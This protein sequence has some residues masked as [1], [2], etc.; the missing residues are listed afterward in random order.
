MF[1]SDAFFLFKYNIVWNE[2]FHAARNTMD[3]F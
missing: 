2:K 1:V 3:L